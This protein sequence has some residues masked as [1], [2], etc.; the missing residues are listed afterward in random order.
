MAG[1]DESAIQLCGRCEVRLDGR[2]VTR[3]LP[4]RQGRLVFAYLACNRSRAVTRDELIDVLWPSGPPAN[5]EDVLGALLSKLRRVL[6]AGA[7][8]GR[9]EVMLVLP[10]EA[11]IDLELAEAAIGR[12]EVAL[13]AGDARLAFDQ[14]Q[15]S[16]STLLLFWG[17][18]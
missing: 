13:G 7:L 14:A 3:S 8:E 10:A 16:S 9:R 18:V 11:S 5:P 6:G 2:T 15:A 12:A 1:L 17:V 4:G